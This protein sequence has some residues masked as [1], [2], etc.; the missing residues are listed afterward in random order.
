MF[1]V[2]QSACC[3]DINLW[4]HLVFIFCQMCKDRFLCMFYSTQFLLR[5]QKW[6]CFGPKCKCFN[7]MNMLQSPE[8][9]RW[10]GSDL[11]DALIWGLFQV[12]LGLWLPVSCIKMAMIHVKASPSSPKSKSKGNCG[13]CWGCFPTFGVVPFAHSHFTVCFGSFLK[14]PAARGLSWWQLQWPLS[15]QVWAPTKPGAERHW[16]RNELE[17]PANWNHRMV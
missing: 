3:S 10:A 9:K 6:S 14:E 16:C 13:C 17:V 15:W 8:C 5:N 12:G 1:A 7:R 4:I 2:Q 11:R